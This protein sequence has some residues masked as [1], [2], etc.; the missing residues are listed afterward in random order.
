MSADLIARIPPELPPVEGHFISAKGR[1][2]VVGLGLSSVGVE[3]RPF[4]VAGEMWTVVE[5]WFGWLVTGLC[6]VIGGWWCLFRLYGKHGESCL[7][8][9]RSLSLVGPS[10]P[11][12]I[13][14][15]PGATANLVQS[16]SGVSGFAEEVAGHN[17][18][19]SG[20]EEEEE[21]EEQMRRAEEALI[22]REKYTGLTFTQRVRKRKQL[23]KGDIV[24]VPSMQQRY[25]PLPEWYSGIGDVDTGGLPSG[26]NFQ[27]G[28]SSSSNE[29]LNLG[30]QGGETIGPQGGET[31]QPLHESRVGDNMELDEY[32]PNQGFRF[33]YVKYIPGIG[34]HYL[35]VL[36]EQQGDVL[37]ACLGHQV[38]SWG[39][40]RSVAR[41]F[42][43]HAVLA[44]MNWLRDT[45]TTLGHVSGIQ[46]EATF[47]C[48]LVGDRYQWVPVSVHPTHDCSSGDLL[49]AQ[50][51]QLELSSSSVSDPNAQNRLDG[52]SSGSGLASEAQ[53]VQDGGSSSTRVVPNAQTVSLS[54]GSE[55]SS[56]AQPIL[57]GGSSSSDADLNAQLGDSVGCYEELFGEE[58][59]SVFPIVG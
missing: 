17:S 48:V 5:W 41:G 59:E 39:Y 54:S 3:G 38:V 52:G 1:A 43:K 45:G 29:P 55:S 10:E 56:E 34:T 30:P 51:S 40:L 35:W 28:G 47:R 44:I 32:D 13:D 20:E 16:H 14:P 27:V 7:D 2:V 26:S 6:L 21:D 23:L 53:R 50:S 9:G 33:P 57:E 24:D 11:V 36:F 58:D 8:P 22:A 31:M 19:S 4:R 15:I 12:G 42:R 18:L 37:L 25:G 46:G 49:I